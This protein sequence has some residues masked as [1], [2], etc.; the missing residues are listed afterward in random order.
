MGWF[1]Q[2]FTSSI[3]RKIIMSLTGLFLILFLVVHLAGNLQLLFNDGGEAFNSYAYMMTHNPLIKVISYG[4]YVFIVLHTIQGILLWLKNRKA[5]GVKASVKTSANASMASKNM[6]LLGTL[7]LAF[8]FIHMGDFWWKMKRGAL[9]MV[10]SESLGHEV[11]DLYERVSVAYSNELLVIVY[12]VGLG[13]LSFHLSHGFQS[14][15]QTLGLNHKKYTPTINTLGKIISIVIPL[16][17]A[18]IPIKMYGNAK[19]LW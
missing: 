10:Q 18:L 3:G 9:N 14:A 17:F 2:F 6:A 5:K 7:I 1:I 11:K 15:F 8:L 4:N 19:G 12:L 16:G 13:V